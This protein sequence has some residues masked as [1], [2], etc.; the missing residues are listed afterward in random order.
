MVMDRTA[1]ADATRIGNT[2]DTASRVLKAL[3]NPNRL[4]I[5]LRLS[6]TCSL[7]SD[8]TAKHPADVCVGD[9]SAELDIAQS[10]VSHHL[11]ELE[12]AGL[13]RMQRRGKN[14]L[15]RVRC[16]TVAE[17]VG[18]IACDMEDEPGTPSVADGLAAL[19]QRE[20]G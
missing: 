10:T 16:D 9:I 8:S 13:I 2:V 6:G 15:C 4:R 18:L 3:S 1:A 17:L 12:Q 11:R 14:I 19:L 7:T 20:S 5:Y